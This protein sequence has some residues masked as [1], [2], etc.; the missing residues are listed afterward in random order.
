MSHHLTVIPTPTNRYRKHKIVYQEDILITAQTLLNYKYNNKPLILN[1]TWLEK[2]I[3][4]YS[5]AYSQSNCITAWYFNP[6][7]DE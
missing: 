6:I 2:T 5:K 7:Y 1:K 4:H 3:N